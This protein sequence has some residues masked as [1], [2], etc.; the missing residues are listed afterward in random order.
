MQTPVVRTMPI[1]RDGG[2]R[3][4][5]VGEGCDGRRGGQGS[6]RLKTGRRE[7]GVADVGYFGRRGREIDRGRATNHNHNNSQTRNKGAEEEVHG[8]ERSEM[9]AVKFL[10]E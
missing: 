7:A 8:L 4:G 6:E 2:W 3:C 5:G 9:A 1:A 10:D